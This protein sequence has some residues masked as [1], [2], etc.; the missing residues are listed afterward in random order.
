MKKLWLMLLSAPLWAQ[1]EPPV[2]LLPVQGD[3]LT[4]EAALARSKGD[5]G[6]PQLSARANPP[7]QGTSPEPLTAPADD[8]PADIPVVVLKDESKNPPPPAEEAKPAAEPAEK[9]AEA[10]KDSKKKAKTKKSAEKKKPAAEEKPTEEK[11]AAS[12]EKPA[13][14]AAEK[15]D[16]QP[17]AVPDAEKPAPVD[18]KAQ[19]EAAESD[20]KLQTPVAPAVGEVQPLAPATPAPTA[21]EEEADPPWAGYAQAQSMAENGNPRGALRQ[22]E[23]RLATNPQDS[24]AAYLKGLVLMQLGRGEEAERW[25]KMMQANFPDLPQSGNALAVIYAGRGD[26]PAAELA[27]RDVLLKHPEHNSARVNLARLYVQMAQAEYEK[28]LKATPDN[29]MIARK[30]EALKAM[31]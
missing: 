12:E 24:R 27:L 17:A 16:G 2:A 21:A 30:L 1:N 11:S 10:K 5:S 22:L 26:L 13:A 7:G 3:T 31:Q 28:A 20:T 8:L 29:A 19:A 23:S 15:K 9:P 14:A 4:P 6:L 25:Y 18:E